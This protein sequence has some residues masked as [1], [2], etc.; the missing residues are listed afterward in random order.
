VVD[1][2][3]DARLLAGQAPRRP[4]LCS[5]VDEKL[6]GMAG[7]HLQ[8]AYHG[9]YYAKGPELGARGARLTTAPWANSTC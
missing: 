9:R 8:Q 6:L 3:V 1:G 7:K 4:S 2:T 5:R